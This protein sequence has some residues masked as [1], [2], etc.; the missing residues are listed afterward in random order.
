MLTAQIRLQAEPTIPP[1]F[2]TEAQPK[3]LTHFVGTGKSMR[4]VASYVFLLPLTTF[5]FLMTS[6][7]N[8]ANSAPRARRV[9]R[10]PGQRRPFLAPYS[11]TSPPHVLDLV[12]LGPKSV[13]SQVFPPTTPVSPLTRES[14]RAERIRRAVDARLTL[15][16][17]MDDPAEPSPQAGAATGCVCPV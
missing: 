13:R 3:A 14:S 5:A 17:G 9:R 2:S 4:I 16:L 6:D 7:E 10:T 12:A 1:R 15:L 8:N 11:T